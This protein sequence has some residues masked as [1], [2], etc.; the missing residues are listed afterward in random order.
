M[1]RRD[2]DDHIQGLG[3]RQPVRVQQRGSTGRGRGEKGIVTTGQLRQQRSAW[4]Y[5]QLADRQAAMIVGQAA[6]FW[7]GG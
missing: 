5:S 3:S 4:K 6:D 7:R 2:R 1:R